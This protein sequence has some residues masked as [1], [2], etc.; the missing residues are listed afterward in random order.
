[1]SATLT[2]PAPIRVGA[3]TIHK[4]VEMESGL[5][6]SMVMPQVTADDLARLR[7]W[8]WDDGLAPDPAA[9]QFMLSIHSYIVQ[10]DGRTILI[11]S[12]NGN[13]K[14]RSIPFAHRLN[15]PWLDRLRALGIEPEDVDMVMCTH[16]HADH[17]GWNTR[18]DGDRWV[19]T[20]PNARYVLGKRDHDFFSTQGHEAFHREAWQDSVLPVIEAGQADIVD[21]HVAVH[22]EIDDGIWLRPAF[23]HSPGCCMIAARRDG[24]EALF[25]GDVIHH[26]V[27]LVRPDLP[28]FADWDG[29]MAMALRAAL[30]AEV[31]DSDTLL[32]PAHFRGVSAGH[33]LRDG[34]RYRFR[35]LG[36]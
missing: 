17:V 6:M 30:L 27:Q 34:D 10:V 14:D 31:A 13:D 1:M 26:P 32:L 28:F 36:D 29:A 20:F 21:E 19:P 24:P 3:L 33:V 2:I 16:L 11:D 22:R 5:P 7:T 9:A 18:R 15:T 25:S 35:F 12:C 8:Y 23:G 4:I